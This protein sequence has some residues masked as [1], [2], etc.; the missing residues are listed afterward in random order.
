MKDLRNVLPTVESNRYT[1]RQA[2]PDDIKYIGAH[3][4]SLDYGVYKYRLS[5]GHKCYC[6][7]SEN[8]VMSYN[9]ISFN[10]CG[11]SFGT[12]REVKFLQL[13]YN[14]AYSYDLYTYK[15]FRKKHVAS[16]LKYYTD[17]DLQRKGKTE[18][19]SLV[20]PSFIA[21]M[22]LALRRGFVPQRIIYIYGINKFKKVIVGTS[23]SL[24]KLHQW[25]KW[26]EKTYG[27]DN[28]K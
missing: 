25:E 10:K 6:A 19:F 3:P 11:I 27:L 8:E 17:L 18:L 24:K 16:Q 15:K 22:K 4:E 1:I 12:E 7:V 5:E 14:Q 21:S 2:N 28:K 13:K 23:K 26:F 9:W 20:G